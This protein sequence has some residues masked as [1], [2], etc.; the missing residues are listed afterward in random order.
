MKKNYD[1]TKKDI[2]NAL[3]RVGLQKG[4]IVFLQS[5]LGFFGKLK[6][7]NNKEELCMIFKNSIFD[8]I[9]TSGTL[10]VPTFSL[11]FCNS[12]TFDKKTTPSVEC[13]IFSEYIRMLPNSCRSND[14]NFSVCAL[15]AKAEILTKNVPEHSFGENSF[16]GRLLKKDGKLCRFNTS[17]DYNTFVHHIEKKLNVPYRYDKEFEGTSIINGKRIKEKFIH[18]VRDLKNEERLPDLSRLEQRAKE[19]GVLKISNLGK[20]QIILINSKKVDEI[21]IKEIKK[22]PNFLIKGKI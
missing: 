6:D 12:Q 14:A 17:P 8:V 9:G 16:W 15:G 3:D 5:N 13:G 10:V 21:I 22:T 20:G 11:S 2:V 18:F 4:N 7:C 19:I 1:Y